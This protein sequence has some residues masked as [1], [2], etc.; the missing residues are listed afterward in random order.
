M[1]SLASRFRHVGLH[2][3]RLLAAAAAG[4]AAFFFLPEAWTFTAR[5]LVAWNLGVW[6][7]LV[8]LGWLMLRSNAEGV[9][10]IAKQEDASSAGLL[11]LMCTAAVLSVAAIMVEMAHARDSGQTQLFVYVITVLTVM[12][13]WLL[14]AA[15]YTFHYAHLFYTA[16]A[17]RQPLVFPDGIKSPS[18]VDFMYFAFTI[19]VAV[20][21]S[22]V[23]VHTTA[24]RAVVLAQSVLSFFFNLAILGLL[25]NIAASVAGVH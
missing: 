20:Q 19:A 14:L 6:P 1:S 25:I 8:A 11:I 23:V 13:S 9:R 15:L 21:T 5:V 12:G 24:M 18:Y 7:Y 17:H 2:R 4:T 22:D 10:T 3:P 16:P